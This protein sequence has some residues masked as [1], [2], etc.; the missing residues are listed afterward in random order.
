MST[1]EIRNAVLQALHRIAPEADLTTLSPDADLREALDID[2]FDFLRFVIALHE[3]LGV[4][5]PETD[6]PKLTT[7]QQVMTYLQAA[8]QV[9]RR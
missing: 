2:S 5:I 1:E 7:L 9:S 4:D 8:L 6:Y 3:T